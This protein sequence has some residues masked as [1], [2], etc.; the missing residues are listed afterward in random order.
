LKKSAQTHLKQAEYNEQA[1]ANSAVKEPG[2]GNILFVPKVG[3]D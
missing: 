2:N 3:N 1:V